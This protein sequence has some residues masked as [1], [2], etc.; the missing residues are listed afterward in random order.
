MCAGPKLYIGFPKL[1]EIPLKGMYFQANEDE[2]WIGDLFI[3]DVHTS[4]LLGNYNKSV[5]TK[6][7]GGLNPR[8]C[9]T[10]STFYMNFDSS[11]I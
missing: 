3:Y 7:S 11:S 4:D 2:V 10:K 6:S 5:G 8:L 9:L 1:N